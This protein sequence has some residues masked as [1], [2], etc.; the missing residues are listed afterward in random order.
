MI[1]MLYLSVRHPAWEVPFLGL[2]IDLIWL[3]HGDGFSFPVFTIGSILVVWL[4][5]PL[6][7]QFLNS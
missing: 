1:C 4:L 2:F 7:N 6:R 5:N 3:S